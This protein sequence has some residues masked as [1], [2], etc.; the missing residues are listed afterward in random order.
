MLCIASIRPLRVLAVN[1]PVDKV[2]EDIN[3][4]RTLLKGIEFGLTNGIVLPMSPETKLMYIVLPLLFTWVP[5]SSCGK[6]EMPAVCKEFYQLSAQQR[7]NDFSTY[8]V[9]KQ[10]SIYRCAVE[11]RPPESGWAYDIA[12]G[13]EKNSRRC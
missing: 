13:G 1:V 12:N 3:V 5:N 11:R 7:E 9:D 6:G 2:A 8:P 10:L 4:H